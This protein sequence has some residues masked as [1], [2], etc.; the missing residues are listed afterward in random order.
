[1]YHEYFIV[2]SAK[3]DVVEDYFYF[4]LVT[5]HGTY[6]L[7]QEI[8]RHHDCTGL[9]GIVLRIDVIKSVFVRLVLA[10]FIQNIFG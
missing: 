2:A 10:E 5:Y 4:L 1:M 3:A 8:G 7:S 9:I 6:T